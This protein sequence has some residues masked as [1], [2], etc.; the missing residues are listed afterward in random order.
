MSIISDILS[1]FSV[2]VLYSPASSVRYIYFHIKNITLLIS[3]IYNYSVF[4]KYSKLRKNKVAYG[5]NF[6]MKN[7]FKFHSTIMQEHI[8]C[9][10]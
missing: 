7:M 5:A 2:I 10:Y 9:R 4:G 8:I 1:T 3:C 6:S